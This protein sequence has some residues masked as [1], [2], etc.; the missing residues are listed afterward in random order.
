M[1]LEAP[2]SE[3]RDLLPSDR[4]EVGTEEVQHRVGRGGEL[5]REVVLVVEVPVREVGG[6]GTSRGDHV[7]HL[8]DVAAQLPG[9]DDMGRDVGLVVFEP[10]PDPLLLFS[11][12]RRLT[13]VGDKRWFLDSYEHC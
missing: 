5:A 12:T 9:G 4:L 7:P 6:L 1:L 13:S 2:S 3:Q 11:C 8:A 10:P